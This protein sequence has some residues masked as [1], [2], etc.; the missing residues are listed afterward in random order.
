MRRRV[1]FLITIPPLLVLI[2]LALILELLACAF[3]VAADRVIDGLHRVS[4]FVGPPD[5]AR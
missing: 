4:D 1:R 3:E 2:P 5:D